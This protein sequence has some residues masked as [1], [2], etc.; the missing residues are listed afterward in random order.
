[1]LAL[2]GVPKLSREAMGLI[3]SV[4]VRRRMAGTTFSGSLLRRAAINILFPFVLV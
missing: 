3:V 2:L 1:V 4:E